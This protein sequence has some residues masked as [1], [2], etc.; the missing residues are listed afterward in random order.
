MPIYIVQFEVEYDDDRLSDN[1]TVDISANSEDDAMK[2]FD[3]S[4][5]II[6][7]LMKNYDRPMSITANAAWEA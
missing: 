7:T 4:R 5:E 3:S 2:R 6:S 1:G